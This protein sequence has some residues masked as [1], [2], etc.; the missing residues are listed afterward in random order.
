[1]TLYAHG[2]MDIKINYTKIKIKYSFPVHEQS[3]QNE[4]ELYKETKQANNIKTRFLVL[5][6]ICLLIICCIENRNSY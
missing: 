6:T 4:M 5:T 2:I 1:M 3:H